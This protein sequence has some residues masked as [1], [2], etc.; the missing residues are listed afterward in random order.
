M[1][2]FFFCGLTVFLAFFPKVALGFS[3]KEARLS[4]DPADKSVKML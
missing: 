4:G 2:F 3:K 1:W